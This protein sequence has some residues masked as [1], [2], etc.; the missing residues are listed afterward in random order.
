MGQ[1]DTHGRQ[2]KFI[3]MIEYFIKL[4]KIRVKIYKD[5]GIDQF[6]HELSS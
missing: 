4:I 1:D 6:I 5:L 3:K 2:T